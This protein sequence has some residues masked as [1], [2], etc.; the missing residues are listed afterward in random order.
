MKRRTRLTKREAEREFRSSFHDYDKAAKRQAW[1][2]FT[3]QL[4]KAGLIT[5]RQYETWTSPF[6][7]D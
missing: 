6:D 4:C 2:N 5:M 1:N 7:N 3:D